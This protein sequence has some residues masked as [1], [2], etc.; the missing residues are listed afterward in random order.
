MSQPRTRTCVILVKTSFVSR[1]EFICSKLPFL[2]A[3]VTGSGAAVNRTGEPP[4][5]AGSLDGS[6]FHAR[7]GNLD[8][9]GADTAG[10]RRRRPTTDDEEL[11]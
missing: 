5:T 1:I 11:A 7:Y 2:S 6:P 9:I 4:G 8:K 10:Y 3:H